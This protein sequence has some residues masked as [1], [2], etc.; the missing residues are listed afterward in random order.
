MIRIRWRWVGLVC[1]LIAA[2]LAARTALP[3]A[4]RVSAAARSVCVPV[5]MYHHISENSA[6]WSRWTISPAELE[7][8]LVYLRE[9]G[10][11]AVTVAS[12]SAWAE[13]E[14]PLPERPVLLT[15][16]DGHES[17]YAYALPLLER[18]DMHAVVNVVGAYC[19]AYTEHEDHTLGYSYLTWNEVAELAA[20]G[21]FEIGSHSYDLHSNTVSRK[22]IC[23]RDGEDR[24]TYRSLFLAD[25]I[26]NHERIY[27]A[28]GAAPFIY[29]YPFGYTCDDADAVL[30]EL[31]YTALLR[32]EQ[33]VA[34]LA[35][36][37]SVLDMGRFNRP[38]GVAPETFF[39]D[40]AP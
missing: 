18:Y 23:R 21:R 3:R 11:T 20:S 9:H 22:G 25:T 17:V 38:H 10:Y 6:R 19:D 1:V 39:R 7:A 24:D 31:G 29:A 2:L 26:A 13:G 16:D 28:T 4:A 40:I 30:S 27:E 33:R 12:L 34:L 14:C 35:D 36:G 32:C 37:D 5:V 15:F 8:D